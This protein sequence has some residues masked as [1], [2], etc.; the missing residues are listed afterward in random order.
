MKQNLYILFMF[1]FLFASC[2]QENDPRMSNT[3]GFLDLSAI[4]TAGAD[5]IVTRAVD[6]DLHLEIWN[7]DSSEQLYDYAPGE[8]PRQLTLEVGEYRLVA[9]TGNYQETYT[10]DQPG[11][12]K[13][14]GECPFSIEAGQVNTVQYAVP[15]TNLAVSLDLPDGFTEW[16]PTYT[17]TVEAAGADAQPLRTITLT[18]GATAYFDLPESGTLTLTYHLTATN[19]DGEEQTA[20]EGSVAQPA[21]GHLYLISYDW[22]TQA[23]ALASI[24]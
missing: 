20:E 4:R 7:A 6:E 19:T 14:Y 13:Y 2:A 17:F 3:Q 18:N 8:S 15:M 10:D 12:A 21:A 24:F 22:A 11:E 16:L 1:L 5:T 23:L 9:Y